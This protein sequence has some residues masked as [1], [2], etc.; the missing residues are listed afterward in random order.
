MLNYAGLLIL[1]K[2]FG[3]GFVPACINFW[4]VAG[5]GHLCIVKNWEPFE[6]RLSPEFDKVIQ[7]VHVLVTCHCK[8][9]GKRMYYTLFFLLPLID[10]GVKNGIDELIRGRGRKANSSSHV[11]HSV[12]RCHFQDN[13]S[14]VF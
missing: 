6:H 7:S 10:T 12:T 11:S 5:K 3:I 2:L 4:R 13:L 14:L 9:N 1:S 8:D